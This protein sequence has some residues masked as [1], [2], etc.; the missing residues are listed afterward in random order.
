MRLAAASAQGRLKPRRLKP[1]SATAS[2]AAAAEAAVM[3]K[4]KVGDCKWSDGPHKLPNKGNG[5]FSSTDSAVV[6][7]AFGITADVRR[8]QGW[9]ERM[10]TLHGNDEHT[11]ADFD[12]AVLLKIR[13]HC[14]RLLVARCHR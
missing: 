6:E 9:Q 7:Q 1:R 5:P 10:L 12:K 4:R 14:D 3:P 8:R 13:R 11:Q 2:E